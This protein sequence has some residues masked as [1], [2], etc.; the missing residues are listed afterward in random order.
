MSS[1]ITKPQLP[2]DSVANIPFLILTQRKELLKDEELDNLKSYLSEY[3]GQL[4]VLNS[5]GAEGEKFASSLNFSIKKM[6]PLSEEKI[7]N[8]GKYKIKYLQN[9]NRTILTHLVLASAKVKNTPNHLSGPAM[10]KFLLTKIQA[11]LPP[12][13]FTKDYP[14]NLSVFK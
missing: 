4:I 9:K 12:F 8:F 2:L 6:F 7:L 5:P 3:N 11:E 14:I 13:Y 10:Y 1:L